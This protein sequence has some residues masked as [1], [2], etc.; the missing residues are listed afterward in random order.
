MEEKYLSLLCDLSCHIALFRRYCI[1]ALEGDENLSLCKSLPT[2]VFLALSRSF[3]M[4]LT[5][6]CF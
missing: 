2:L 3:Y 5:L 6:Q 4:M 1:R